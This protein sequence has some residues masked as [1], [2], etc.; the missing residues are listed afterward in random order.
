MY[1]NIELDQVFFFQ[2]SSFEL[3]MHR[4]IVSDCD[5]LQV[6]HDNQKWLNYTREESVAQALKAGN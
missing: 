2:C 6:M 4:Y 3:K 5:S 1:Q